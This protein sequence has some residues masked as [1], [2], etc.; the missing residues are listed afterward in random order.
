MLRIAP[1]AAHYFEFVF[2]ND[3]SF[4]VKSQNCKNIGLSYGEIPKAVL[5]YR[6]IGKY[7]KADNSYR[8]IGI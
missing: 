5:R 1:E 7:V 6:I 8:G 3:E 4:T 2:Q